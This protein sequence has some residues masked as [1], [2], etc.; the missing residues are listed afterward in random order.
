MGD[1]RIEVEFLT[2][3]CA[4]ADPF[5]RERA[6][7]PPAPARLFAALASAAFETN[8][9]EGLQTLRWL[10]TLPAPLV[11]AGQM[12]PRLD[13]HGESPGHYVPV[14]DSRPRRPVCLAHQR[15]APGAPGSAHP[16]CHARS[17]SRRVG[18][19]CPRGP[20]GQSDPASGT[21]TGNPR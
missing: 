19:R 10:E 8:D 2:G 9:E 21:R 3:R 5:Q 11:H 20:D 14:N 7:W 18:Q 4:A 15:A 6:E 13:Q 17:V 1:L 12:T 16:A